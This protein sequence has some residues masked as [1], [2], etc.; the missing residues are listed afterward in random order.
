MRKIVY[1]LLAAGPLCWLFKLPYLLQAWRTSPLDRWDWIALLAAFVAAVSAYAH[2]PAHLRQRQFTLYRLIPLGISLLAFAAAEMVSVNS[3]SL[4]SA[5]AVWWSC[6]FA[7]L[8]PGF[9]SA[10]L[11]AFFLLCLACTSSTY[12]I[13]YFLSVSTEFALLLKGMAAAVLLINAALHVR[14]KAETAAFVLAFLGGMIVWYNADA[15]SRT[16]GPLILDLDHCPENCVM[17]ELAPDESSRRFFRNS[18]IRFFSIADNGGMYH[19]LEIRKPG[20]IH[21]IHPASHCLRSGG[22]EIV[23]EE[24][25]HFR[26][27]GVLIPLTV[28]LTKRRTGKELFAVWYSSHEYS[29]SGFLAFRRHWNRREDWRIYQISVQVNGTAEEARNDLERMIN[30]LALRRL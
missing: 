1:I 24:T 18:T 8:T 10:L 28:I 19:L 16:S 17:R 20:D 7:A 6:C 26:V 21:S 9:A 29:C 5:V 11:P 4:V 30:A 27:R 25:A 2:T 14:V 22:R 15:L 12:W 3:F 13:G 23:S